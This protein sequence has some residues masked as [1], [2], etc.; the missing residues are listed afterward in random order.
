MTTITG[1]KFDTPDGANQMLALVKPLSRQ[2]LITVEDAAI[3]IWPEGNR[4]PKTRHLDD[5]VGAGELGGTFWGL[6]FG[7]IF[8]IPFYGMAVGATVGSIAGH[9]SNYG[10]D[11]DFVKQARDEVTEGTSALFLMTS[12]AVADKVTEAVRE[13]GLKFDCFH[14][15]LSYEQE[16]FLLEDLVAS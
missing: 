8:F 14:T 12:E 6:L 16:Q 11:K 3:V 15:N 1:Y 7:L 13:S 9:Y 4:N 5:M 2:G 10:I